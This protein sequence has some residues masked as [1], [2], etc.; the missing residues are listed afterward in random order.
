MA[1]DVRQNNS[2]KTAILV[3]FKY[4]KTLFL[5]FALVPYLLSAESP[6]RVLAPVESPSKV[7]DGLEFSVITQSEWRNP[8][9]LIHSSEPVILQIR[10]TNR[11]KNAILFPTFDSFSV[12]FI[13][14][15]GTNVRLGGGRDATRITPNILLQPGAGF[16]M[17]VDAIIEY[18]RS[19]KDVR[20]IVKD[21]TGTITTATLPAGE[22]SILFDVAPTHYDFEKNTKLSA[23]LWAGRGSTESIGFKVKSP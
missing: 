13:A 19:D 22:Y 5:C 14:S 11:T 7:I 17:P 4:M 9:N 16:S 15:D 3:S 21:G 20:L 6:T 10:I 12:R 1:F 23:P 2:K 8:A 18:E